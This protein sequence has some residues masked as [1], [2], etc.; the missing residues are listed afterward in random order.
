MPRSFLHALTLALSFAVACARKD[1]APAT[2]DAGATGVP[3][4]PGSAVA[5]P[6][7]PHPPGR[8][9]CHVKFSGAEESEFSGMW[10]PG[11]KDD[12]VTAASDYWATDA[13]VRTALR[14]G[15]KNKDRA[16][17]DREIGA[18]MEHDPHLVILG[19]ECISDSGSLV[20]VSGEKSTYADIPFKPGTYKLGTGTA[21]SAP[22]G[23]FAVGR[24]RSAAGPYLDATP[25]TLTLTKFDAT[26]VAGSFSFTAT[27]AS[28]KAPAK[29]EGT[30]DLPCEP[31]RFGRCQIAR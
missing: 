14:A 15:I 30:F 1:G 29:I 20:I 25:G 8:E 17:V 31:N 12:K 7:A 11:R 23:D 10:W 22:A 28:T 27:S 26:G 18:H 5:A 16:E 4:A 19:I 24:L 9:A 3:G 21:K 13:E 2:A 6:S